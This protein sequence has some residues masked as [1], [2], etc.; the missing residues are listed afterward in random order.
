MPAAC[1]A[2]ESG[3]FSNRRGTRVRFLDP[4]VKTSTHGA[5]TGA[6]KRR[7]NATRLARRSREIRFTFDVNERNDQLSAL[8]LK[9]V[10]E[11]SRNDRFPENSP[12]ERFARKYY[13]YTL[14]FSPFLPTGRIFSGR[15][16]IKHVARILA[17]KWSYFFNVY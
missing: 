3:V 5:K 7:Q 17:L 16:Y 13:M 1:F 4:R 10:C 8:A 2:C 12:A 14:L 11:K 6:T 15:R 9:F